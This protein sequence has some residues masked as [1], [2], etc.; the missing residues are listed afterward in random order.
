MKNIY[1]TVGPSQIY[2]TVEDHLKQAVATDI[3]SLSHRGPAFQEMYRHVEELLKELLNIPEDYVIFFLGSSIE[4]MERIIQNTVEKTSFHFVDGAFSQ[5]AASIAEELQKNVLKIIA[6]EASEYD[7]D[8]LDIPEKAELIFITENDTSTGLIFPHKEI[9]ALKKRYPEKL[10]AVDL[11]SSAP[12]SSLDI[13]SVDMAFFSGQKGFG[14]PAGLSI[15]VVSPQAMN[16]AAKLKAKGINIGS[17]HSFLS[18]FESRKK[19]MTPETPNVLA[20]YLLEKVLEDMKAK[21]IAGIRS[22]ITAKADMIYSFF[23]TTDTIKP[24]ISDPL[25]Q[26]PSTLVL[27]VKGGSRELREKLKRN[28]IIVGSG[29]GVNKDKHIRIA[30]FPAHSIHDVEALI[31]AIRHSGAR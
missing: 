14:I 24:F 23:A 3:L 30:N 22:E 2:P 20:I 11:V 15:V 5:K 19:W 10:I 1:F 12:F 6:P 31:D 25:Y 28:G 16:K 18:L 26:S 21:S 7:F 4:A 27:S 29:Y 17:Y 9:I 8:G 13:S